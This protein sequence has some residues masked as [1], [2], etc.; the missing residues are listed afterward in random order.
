MSIWR[1]SYLLQLLLNFRRP[2]N[3]RASYRI[4]HSLYTWIHVVYCHKTFHCLLRTATSIHIFTTSRHCSQQVWPA[5]ELS[6]PVSRL[7]AAPWNI[8]RVD[9][10]INN[11]CKQQRGGHGD[12]CTLT[13][14]KYVTSASHEVILL[15]ISVQ[16]TLFLLLVFFLFL[17]VFQRLSILKK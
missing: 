12:G 13:G 3:K 14:I 6:A 17:S 9:N 11:W 4:L 16:C 1:L 7:P 2:N 5:S 15:P 8:P 10:M